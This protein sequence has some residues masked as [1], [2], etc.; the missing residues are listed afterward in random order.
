MQAWNQVKVINAESGF[1][2]QA[3]LVVRVEKEGDKSLVAV[4]LD[5]TG[6]VENFDATELQLL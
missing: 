2:G 3:G 4:R 5:T 6:T 1:N